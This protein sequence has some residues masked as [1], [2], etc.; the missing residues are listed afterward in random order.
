MISAPLPGFEDWLYFCHDCGLPFDEESQAIMI[1]QAS[2]RRRM[3][4][5]VCDK[6]R[7]KASVYKISVEDQRMLF[8]GQGGRCAICGLEFDIDRS[9]AQIDHDHETGKVRGFLCG[10]CNRMLGHA[11]DDLR[12]LR[13]AQQYLANP[14][15]SMLIR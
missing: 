13:N 3:L 2:S 11:K 12:R 1:E 7:K 10:S 6:A 5:I 4:C 15:A 9:D 14:P 8:Y